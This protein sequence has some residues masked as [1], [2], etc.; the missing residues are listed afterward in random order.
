MNLEFK[1]VQR[2][3][4]DLIPLDINPRKITEARRMKMIESLQKFNLVDLPVIDSDN[5]VIS[6]HQR[7]RALQAI[8]RGDEVIDVRMPNRKLTD[9]EVKE[10]NLL[11]NTHFGE[12]DFEA[13][14]L[15]FMD[16]DFKGL[17]MEDLKMEFDAFVMGDLE[18]PEAKEADNTK[19][20]PPQYEAQEDDFETPEVAEIK[21][22]IVIG[23]LIEFKHPDGRY[24]R[25]LCGDSTKKED[26]ERL[27]DGGKADMVFTDP[28]YGYKYESNYQD[29]HKELLNDDK[30]LNF[31]PNVNLFTKENIA[32]YIF[33]GWQTISEWIK[34]VKNN[35]LN[36]KNIIVWKKNNWSMGD[37]KGCYG[38]QYVFLLFAHKGRIELKNGRG[39][40]IW[41]FNRIPPK[42][43]PT[44]K[45]I[46]LIEKAINDTTVVNDLILDLFGGSGSTMV[47]SYPMHRKA[48]LMELDEKYC[49]VITDRM[50]KLDP[51][52]IITKNGIE[53]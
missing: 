27:M 15:D 49:Q 31:L 39:Q 36:L 2:T 32:V 53:I 7:L 24:H 14:E 22:D 18:N 30:I 40:D 8:G 46:N 26:V 12:F 13:L 52:L 44:I 33:C 20:L 25:L 11:A 34:E 51:D 4:N 41:E 29:K 48:Y 37:L 47:A 45:P 21:T 9:K 6:G 16:V 5:T 10:Y 3:V 23:D 1:T 28:P 35:N 17:G 19:S 43:H 38:G 42:E 50:R